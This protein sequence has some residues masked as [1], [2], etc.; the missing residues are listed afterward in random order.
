MRLHELFAKLHDASITQPTFWRISICYQVDYKIA[1]LCYKAVKLQQPS[2]LTSVPS[3]YRQWRVLRSS[4]SDLY[5]QHSLHRQTL[6][7]FGSHAVLPPSGT[8]FPHLYAPLTVSLVLDLSA[9][10]TCSQDIYSRFAVHASDTLTRSFVRYKFVT[11]LL[12]DNKKVRNNDRLI[13]RWLLVL[14][15]LQ[16]SFQNCINFDHQT[17][18]GFLSHQIVSLS[19][20]SVS[21]AL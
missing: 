8:V 16:I 1:V 20:T 3:P 12:T 9:I 4:A 19:T 18:C 21:A 13:Y 14:I 15:F 6:L 2:Y 7:L 10:L 5:C 17:F 11:Y